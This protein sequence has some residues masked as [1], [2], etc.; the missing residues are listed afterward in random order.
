MRGVDFHRGQD[1][2][3]EAYQNSRK[4][5]VAARVFSFFRQGGNAVESD[6][7][8]YGERRAS[9]NRRSPESLGIV[10]RTGKE[11][12]TFVRRVQDVARRGR[13]KNHD[14]DAH[15]RRQNFVDAR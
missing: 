3:D 6:V 12:Q 10:K 4:Q 2:R 8:E 7:G 1:S 9:E 14:H 11:S 5:N 15:A 13:E